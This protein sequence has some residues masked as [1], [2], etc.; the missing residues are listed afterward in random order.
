MS[1][2]AGAD[3]QAEFGKTTLSAGYQNY[4]LKAGAGSTYMIP[5]LVGVKFPF[6]DK[7]YGHAQAGYGFGE[8][9]GSGAFGYA[10]SIGTSIGSK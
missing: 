7:V 9:S 8:G 4:S 3:L 5:L 2:A 6:S 10:P 1:F